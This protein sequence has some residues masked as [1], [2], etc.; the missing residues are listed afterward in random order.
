VRQAARLG[1]DGSDMTA[2]V[3]PP[4]SP[5]PDPPLA[6]ATPTPQRADRTRRAVMAGVVI[7]V[8]LG[9]AVRAYTSSDLWLD[10]ALTVDIA[11]LSPHHLVSALRH[12]GSPPFYY[13]LLHYWIQLFGSGDFAVRSLSS[14]VSIAALPCAWL[15]GRRLAGPR[16]GLAALLLL[17]SSPFALR[18]AT[19]TR[20]YSLLVLE[21]LL[22][23]IA[24]EASLRTGRR[25][26]TAG[27]GVAA[28]A[29]AYTHYWALFLLIA[30]V[31]WLAWSAFPA[32]LGRTVWARRRGRP[33]PVAS[34]RHRR[35]LLAMVVGG[36]F[37]LPQLP[38]LLFQSRH[39]GT[40]WAAQAQPRVVLDTLLGWGGPQTYVWGELLGAAIIVLALLGWVAARDGDGALLLSPRR[41]VPGP[42]LAGFSLGPLVIA[43]VLTAATS[44]G[45]V[46][47]YTAV[48]LPAWI[49]LAALG[50]S[51]LPPRVM[52]V[53]LVV[54][55]VVG[56]QTGR[57]DAARQRTE[58]GVIAASIAV[59]T[60]PGDVVVYC[61]DQVAPAVHRLIPPGRIEISAGDAAG[62]SR[63][64]WVDYAARNAQLSGAALAQQALAAAGPSHSIA[65]VWAAGYRT[66]GS[67][68]NDLQA[69]LALARPSWSQ[70]DGR[71]TGLLESAALDVFVPTT[72][73]SSGHD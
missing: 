50:A 61:P 64:D 40:P 71:N 10:E 59:S 62:P 55:S 66:W 31:G 13:L 8:G 38:T 34:P 47:R 17:A 7:L 49:L 73:A 56:L 44:A 19:E 39:T 15:L 12:D 21:V 54:L 4:S 51:R 63:V 28:V 14:L 2:T 23:G 24:L 67:I 33:A 22:G 6:V 9:I 29:L 20:M 60:L 53:V 25:A 3:R 58:A 41:A 27:V 70:V 5:L 52:A 16:A 57:F 65:L 18:Y 68:C 11:R 45:Y 69:S 48:A 42:L 43:A 1:H 36:V 32:L 30:V 46:S 72:P 35:P 37:F 26:P